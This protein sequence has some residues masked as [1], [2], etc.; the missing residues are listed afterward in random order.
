MEVCFIGYAITGG[1][2]ILVISI[3]TKPMSTLNELKI[4]VIVAINNIIMSLC[5]LTVERC[6]HCKNTSK[7]ENNFSD[8]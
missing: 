7:F 8:Q 6:S 3:K 2:V 1:P 4:A 5:R